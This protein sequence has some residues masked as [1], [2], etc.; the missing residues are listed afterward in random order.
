MSER[1]YEN[2]SAVG[3]LFFLLSILLMAIGPLCLGADEA[4]AKQASVTLRF[5]PPNGASIAELSDR[6][7]VICSKDKTKVFRTDHDVMLTQWIFESNS[8]GYF[9]AQTLRD[10]RGEVNHK[11]YDNPINKLIVGRTNLLTLSSSGELLNLKMDERLISDL[12]L[13]LPTNM[14]AQIDRELGEK[15]VL[16]AEKDR[17]QFNVARLAG[18]TVKEGDIWKEEIDAIMNNGTQYKKHYLITKVQA[19][20]HVGKQVLVKTITMDSSNK[21]EVEAIRLDAIGAPEETARFLGAEASG[22]YERMVQVRTFDAATLVPTGDQRMTERFVPTPGGKEAVEKQ[23]L[24]YSY[25]FR[26]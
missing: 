13:Q 24:L 18:K 14:H 12:K 7:T 10:V 25:E 1:I 16:Q 4:P 23:R 5:R 15:A 11:P 2:R 17:W 9:L 3:K 26:K 21:D 22:A 8:E 20:E 6:T 19:L